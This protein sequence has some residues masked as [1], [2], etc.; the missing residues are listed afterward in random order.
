MM[1]SGGSAGEG[2]ALRVELSA[3]RDGYEVRIGMGRPRIYI[4]REHVVGV[5][6]R[7]KVDRDVAQRHVAGVEP[8][9]PVIFDVPERRRQPRSRGAGEQ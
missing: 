7:L 2:R 9:K 6:S 8:G 3:V 4:G 1:V 5:L